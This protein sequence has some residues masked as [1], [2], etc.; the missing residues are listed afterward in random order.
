MGSTQYQACGF[1]GSASFTPIVKPHWASVTC[2]QF[3]Y[4]L[5]NTGMALFVLP[6][7]AERLNGAN[8]SVWVGIYLAVCGLTQLVCPVAGKLSDHHSSKYGRRRP[9]IVVG[10]A[11]TILSFAVMR[12][13]SFMYWPK[14]YLVFLFVGELALNIV[15]SAQCGLPADLQGS[16]KGGIAD[17]AE[18]TKGIVSGYVALHSFMGAIAAMAMVFLT[19]TY[20]VQAEY[21]A[22]MMSL[23]IACCVVCTSVKESPTDHLPGSY[24]TTMSWKDLGGSYT[25]D[26]DEDMDF[27]WVCAGRVFYYISTSGVVFLYYYIRDLVVLGDEALVRSHL[28]ILVI[29]AQ[30]V[31]A[32]CSIPCSHLSNKI[33][34]KSVIYAANALMATTFV[35]YT[36]APKMGSFAW[37]VVLLAGICYG[38]GSGAYLSVDYALAL[39]CMPAKKTTAEAFGLWGVAGFVGTTIGPLVGGMLLS[40][41]IPGATAQPLHRWASGAEEYSYIGY[42]LV[43][44][45]TGSVM[46]G[47]VAALTS[48]I[49][50]LPEATGGV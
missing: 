38:I 5:V 3:V 7:E 34:R 17:D 20:A 11:V 12:T 8:G 24:W 30:L 42:A 22:Y 13:A 31:G 23:A 25:I 26:M 44:L 39:D 14:V 41:T 4:S 15:F 16:S 19:R 2:F 32:A 37:P 46:N 43:L 6:L 27:F 28:A 48:R 36:I 45:G 29:L 1:K 10:T 49:Q 47:V 9:F 50:G 21:P 18:G 35:L 40:S 33:G